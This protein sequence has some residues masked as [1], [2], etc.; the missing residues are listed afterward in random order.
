VLA[1]AKIGPR[2]IANSLEPDTGGAD[3]RR[4]LLD[5]TVVPI[6]MLLWN[7]KDACEQQR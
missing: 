1:V 3:V 4:L 2:P 7:K 6:N 5:D